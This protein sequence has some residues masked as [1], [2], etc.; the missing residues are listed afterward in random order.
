M[1]SLA[2]FILPNKWATFGT[3]IFTHFGEITVFELEKYLATT[4]LV[5]KTQM[6]NPKSKSEILSSSAKT[7]K[8]K[9]QKHNSIT[10]CLK[11]I[12]TH[13]IEWYAT[14]KVMI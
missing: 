8:S 11:K 14:M 12:I 4:T 7:H 5:V 3:E 13:V 10:D 1:W 6:F 9:N 2:K